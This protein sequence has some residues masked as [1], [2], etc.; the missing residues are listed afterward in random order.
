MH[1][2][3]S[4]F[5]VKSHFAPL[6][7]MVRKSVGKEGIL[8]Y[9]YNADPTTWITCHTFQLSLDVPGSDHIRGIRSPFPKVRGIGSHLDCNLGGIRFLYPK[10]RR[11]RSQC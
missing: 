2:I 10:S 3:F 7:R 6:W 9:K 5:Q 8:L 4:Y 1:L 11:I